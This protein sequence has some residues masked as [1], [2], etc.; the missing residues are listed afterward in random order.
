MDIIIIT[1]TDW[2][3]L[4]PSKKEFNDLDS[5]LSSKTSSEIAYQILHS[6][7]ISYGLAPC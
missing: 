5:M 2:K 4:S 3:K 7:Q 1:Y 6:A